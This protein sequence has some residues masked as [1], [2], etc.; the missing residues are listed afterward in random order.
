M[1]DINGIPTSKQMIATDLWVNF[2]VAQRIAV[3]NNVPYCK[4]VAKR[5]KNCIKYM[6]ENMIEF[7]ENGN[8]LTGSLK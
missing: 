4:S 1:T 3:M 5:F 8:I 6:V 7:S 2:T